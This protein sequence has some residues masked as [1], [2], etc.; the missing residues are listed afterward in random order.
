M[1]SLTDSL[2]NPISVRNRPRTE[3]SPSVQS[4]SIQSLS[5]QPP[6]IQLPRDL[7]ETIFHFAAANS[8]DFCHSI[9]KVS[10]WSRSLAQCYLFVTLTITDAKSHFRALQI[11][12][13][14]ILHQPS[15]LAPGALVQ[16]IWMD[17]FAESFVYIVE[18]CP[19]LRNLAIR[20]SMFESLSR[21]GA[22]NHTVAKRLSAEAISRIQE[23]HLFFITDENYRWTADLFSRAE[24]SLIFPK[25]KRLRF[26]RTW[27]C[28]SFHFSSF[29]LL[30]HLALP[31]CDMRCHTFDGIDRLLK[32]AKNLEMLVVIIVIDSLDE[33]EQQ[34]VENFILDK[35]HAQKGSLLYGYSTLSMNVQTEWFEEMK[36]SLSIW[37]KAIEYTDRLVHQH[38][39]VQPKIECF[40]PL[41]LFDPIQLPHELIE[42][43]FHFAAAVSED[44]CRSICRLS[45]WTRALAQRHLF[46][47]LTIKNSRSH[48]RALQ[49]SAGN[50]LHQPS[51]LIPGAIVRNIWMNHVAESF[52]FIFENCPNLKN[53]A[54]RCL[55]FMHLTRASSR[56]ALIPLSN[57]AMSRK[58]DLHLLFIIEEGVTSH[59][60]HLFQTM[61]HP[62]SFIFP[63]ITRL[64]WTFTKNYAA[65]PLSKFTLLTHLALPYI[66]LQFDA[67]ELS[68]L[69]D[70]TQHLKMLVMILMVD[71]L[72]ERER[73]DVENYIK[74][75]RCMSD[76]EERLYGYPMSSQEVQM[77]WL[78]ETQG[79]LDIWERAIQYT[80]LLVD[81]LE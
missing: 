42:T 15:Q 77:E 51:Q 39:L 46:V 43:I 11:T 41:Q 78:E 24:N 35:R 80:E 4:S 3:G 2:Q 48:F 74:M 16:N 66:A 54:I 55:E 1:P 33:G 23:L 40:D 37:E 17:H 75:K 22:S 13:G 5:I 18:S 14:R 59:T 28:S 20:C 70:A 53:L 36:G 32:S 67:F 58:Q 6:P 34:K 8:K 45:T 10:T 69:L 57:E 12:A 38:F 31:C 7:I 81:Q 71:R 21:A 63:R 50:I 61:T 29:N 76:P 44:F 65:I 26:S 9:C 27:D 47:T 72:H 19:N 52:V 30:T 25:I 64:R 49:I 60:L 79:G 62:S 68:R 56:T 73:R